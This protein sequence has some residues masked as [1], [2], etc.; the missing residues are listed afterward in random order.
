MASEALDF[1]REMDAVEYLMFRGE[2]N[3]RSR[4]AMMSVALLDRGAKGVHPHEECKRST[5]YGRFF[6][7][8]CRLL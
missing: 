2:Q 3:P 4:S 5:H 7:Q 1:P 8:V 6:F